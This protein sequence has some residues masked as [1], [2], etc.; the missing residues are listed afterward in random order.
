MAKSIAEANPVS[1]TGRAILAAIS[2]GPTEGLT[3]H[4]LTQA[5]TQFATESVNRMVSVLKVRGYVDAVRDLDGVTRFTLTDL[6]RTALTAPPPKKQKQAPPDG[7]QPGPWVHPIRAT[8][9]GRIRA[10]HSTVTAYEP[11]PD[12]TTQVRP[13]YPPTRRN[14]SD[15]V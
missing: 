8:L 15:G 1:K 9:R 12:P 4:R 7:W 3:R 6:G 5:V 2:A 11:P 14:R 13:Y 10:Y